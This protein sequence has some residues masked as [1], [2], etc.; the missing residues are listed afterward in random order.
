MHSLDLIRAFAGTGGEWVIHLL[1]LASVLALGIIAERVVLL[2]RS[3]GGEAAPLPQAALDAWRAGKPQEALAALAGRPLLHEAAS[4]LAAA[5]PSGPAEAEQALQ[6]ALG[7]ARQRL[8]RRLTALGTLGNN[9]PFI[10][11]LG[12]V[13]GVIRAFR[14]LSQSGGGAETVMRGLSE[15][16]V[17]TAV[18]ILVAIPCVAAYNL[19]TRA[20]SERLSAAEN[21]GRRLIA[22]RWPAGA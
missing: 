20:V 11:L 3:G 14:D 15:A 19:L 10:G 13:L 1:V 22:A 21:A 2:R 9:A 17:A 16:L 12:T 4:S 18:G 8:E 6:E 7:L 5:S